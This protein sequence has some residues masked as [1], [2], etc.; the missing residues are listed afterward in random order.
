[1]DKLR[2]RFGECDLALTEGRD[3]VF[4][5]VNPGGQWLFAEIMTSVALARA[6]LHPRAS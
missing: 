1:M 6:L 3:Y 5:E 2:L 4:F